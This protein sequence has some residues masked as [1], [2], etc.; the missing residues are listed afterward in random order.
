MTRFFPIPNHQRSGND[1]P[2]KSGSVK[3][4]LR[5][6]AHC[7]GPGVPGHTAPFFADALLVSQL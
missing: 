4:M 2:S 3:H 7:A 5:G 1:G 6:H